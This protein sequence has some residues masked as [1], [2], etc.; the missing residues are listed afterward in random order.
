MDAVEMEALRLANAAMSK[1]WL[2]DEKLLLIPPIIPPLP[3]EN[4][5]SY[6]SSQAIQLDRDHY[7]KSNASLNIWTMLD[8]EKI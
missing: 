5:R 3:E 2:V 4:V 7:G 8:E 6:Y 1:E